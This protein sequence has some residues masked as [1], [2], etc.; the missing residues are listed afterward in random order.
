MSAPLRGVQVSDPVIAAARRF[1][2]QGDALPVCSATG[3]F[4]GMLTPEDIVTGCVA[5]GRDPRGT[6]VGSLLHGPW[7]VLDASQILGPEVLTA[8]LAQRLPFL[9]VLRN[10]KLVGLLTMDALAGHLLDSIDDT[11]TNDTDLDDDGWWPLPPE[12]KQDAGPLPNRTGQ[13]PRRHFPDAAADPAKRPE[14]PT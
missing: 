5:A 13:R 7:P 11:E 10:G 2:Y 9:P 3:E 8:L 14:D 1:R 4:V 12:R 6:P